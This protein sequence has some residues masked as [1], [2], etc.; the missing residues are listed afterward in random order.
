M[1]DVERNAILGNVQRQY[2]GARYVPKFFQGPDGTP[3]WVGNVP[4]EALTIVTYLGNSYTSKVPVPA[5]IGNP[6]QNPTYWAL[7]GN[8]NAQVEEYRQEVENLVEQTSRP[9][10]YKKRKIIVVGDS[11]TRGYNP[12]GRITN[13]WIKQMCN[14]LG[15][16]YNNDVY[17]LSSDGAG[18][19]ISGNLYLTQLQNYNGATPR[20]KITDIW[21]VGGYNDNN[22]QFAAITQAIQ[23]FMSYASINYP[24]A[25]VSNMF[26]G[27]SNDTATQFRLWQTTRAAYEVISKLG[28]CSYQLMN[29]ILS[30]PSYRASDGFHPTQEAHNFL[31]QSFEN[32]LLA[33]TPLLNYS[34]K[35]LPITYPLGNGN[36]NIISALASPYAASIYSPST[37]TI[38]NI[39]SLEPTPFHRIIAYNIADMPFIPNSSFSTVTTLCSADNELAVAVLRA[40]ML[41]IQIEISKKVTSTL[42]I[43]P[44]TITV[45]RFSN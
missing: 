23:I 33:N 45:P 22:A 26:V 31:A 4:Y 21:V 42:S 25:L 29:T 37:I 38:T 19:T 1:T 17:D 16:K 15:L 10:S 14:N 9:F 44:F 2:V 20:D 12:D 27:F 28:G 3:T 6:S 34:Y 7:T 11:Y 30:P 32:V 5:G 24:N 43:F 13:T 39:G 36:V 18:F 41:G 8:F 40:D 35:Q